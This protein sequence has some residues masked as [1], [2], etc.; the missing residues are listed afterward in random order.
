MGYPEVL[1]A[2]GDPTRRKLFETL[3]ERP[4]TVGQLA[5]DQLVS[6]PAASQHLKVSDGLS[7]YGAEI[8]R[9][10]KQQNH[11]RGESNEEVYASAFRF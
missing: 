9:R 11:Q 8:A 5:Q 3:R 6:R 2:L 7:A 10:M 4:M 1:S